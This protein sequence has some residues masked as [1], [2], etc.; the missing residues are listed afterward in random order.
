MII[1]IVVVKKKEMFY[2]VTID[3][4]GTPSEVKT[5][6]ANNN[7]ELIDEANQTS[8]QASQPHTS[9]AAEE[10]PFEPRSDSEIEK[11]PSDA[12]S[13]DGGDSDSID[14]LH[15]EA[16]QRDTTYTDVALDIGKSTL[17]Y[18][19][20]IVSSTASYVGSGADYI[21]KRLWA[22]GTEPVEDHENPN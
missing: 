19:C 4:G 20:A 5:S 14:D 10:K 13:A 21:S 6:A 11:A 12:E 15:E 7:I 22:P 8:K 9:D 2:K 16:N 3:E 1:A 18:G 17:G